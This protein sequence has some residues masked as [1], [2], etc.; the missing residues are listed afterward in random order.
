MDRRVRWFSLVVALF[1]GTFATA[2]GSVAVLVWPVWIV[3]LSN[4]TLGFALWFLWAAAKEEWP[5][6]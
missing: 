4:F 5:N 2:I 3:T 1:S 6:G